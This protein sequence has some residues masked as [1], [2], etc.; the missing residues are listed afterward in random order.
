M[1]QPTPSP[2]K[3]HSRPGV[4][5]L[6]RNGLATLVA[7]ALLALLPALVSAQTDDGARF[8]AIADKLDAVPVYFLERM[9]GQRYTV[10]A[11]QDEPAVAP[12]FFYAE[13]ARSLRDDLQTREP[14][15]ETSVTRAGLGEI[16]MSI[17]D[18]E[19]S[20]VSYALI[21]EPRQVSEARR[22]N[23]DDD[24]SQA[25]VFA[26]QREDDGRFLP[27]RD[28]DGTLQLPLFIESQ[29]ARAAVEVMAQQNPDREDEL[30]VSALPLQTAVNDMVSGRLDIE[31][32]IFIPPR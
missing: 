25:P 15:V 21:G 3:Q 2:L 30:V 16:Y 31:S 8:E 24:F 18:A 9:N 32:V 27:M 13:S 26:V 19:E 29:R 17:R 14:P 20:E 5:R 4:D 11:G 1:K 10:D 28:T 22:I 12:V 6:A 23:Q 7:L